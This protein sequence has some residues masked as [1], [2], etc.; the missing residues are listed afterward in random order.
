MGCVF[1]DSM[2]LNDVSKPGRIRY[3]LFDNPETFPP[4]YYMDFE[5]SDNDK[6]TNLTSTQE[7]MVVGLQN[8]LMRVNT[9]PSA[10]DA[11]FSRGRVWGEIS[12]AVGIVGPRAATRVTIEGLPPLVA[13]IDRNHGLCGTDGYR[14]YYLTNGF[15][16]KPKV[17]LANLEPAIL[18]NYPGWGALV[19]FVP[20]PDSTVIDRYF[21][22]GYRP[23]RR[24]G[25]LRVLGPNKVPPSVA[26]TFRRSST[27][28]PTMLLRGR[29]AVVYL[30]DQGTFDEG[31]TGRSMRVKTREVYPSGV[32]SEA[33]TE[34][35][36]LRYRELSQASVK[37]TLIRTKEGRA[38]LESS[39]LPAGMPSKGLWRYTLGNQLG[40]SFQAEF[41]TVAAS[42][43]NHIVAIDSVTFAG[44]SYG[45]AEG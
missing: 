24:N 45:P 4:A 19:A 29:D 39:Q 15:D 37:A 22:F 38:A 11:E 34:R 3:S 31:G 30:E 16:W 1:E 26:A 8:H 14:V 36:Y 33:K 40:E 2:V 27:G 23:T 42:L 43:N 18:I 7:V 5:T 9:L 6:V 17:N 12:N 28:G 41:E 10:S 20:G 13:F 44:K 21:Y 25:R 32:G 35:L